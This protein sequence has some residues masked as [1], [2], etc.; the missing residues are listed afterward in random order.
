LAATD[1]LV[2]KQLLAIQ[3]SH[4]V[5]LAANSFLTLVRAFPVS[6]LMSIYFVLTY[7]PPLQNVGRVSDAFPQNLFKECLVIPSMFNHNHGPYGPRIYSFVRKFLKSFS[8]I[9]KKLYF[10]QNVK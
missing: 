8:K 4:H 6:D 5:A 1:F 2:W 9:Q 3:Q 7:K 10:F